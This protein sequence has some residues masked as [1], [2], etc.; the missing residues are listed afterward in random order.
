MRLLTAR[1]LS[2]ILLIVSFVLNFGGVLLYGGRTTYGW[3]VETP[4][5]LTWARGL[6]IATKW[7]FQ[8]RHWPARPCTNP[9]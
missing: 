5:L 9:R 3:F 6:F 4:T 1:R 2:A 8:S 7:D